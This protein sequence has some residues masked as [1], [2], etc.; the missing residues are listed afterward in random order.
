VREASVARS[1][2]AS[3]PSAARTARASPSSAAALA[4]AHADA[5]VVVDQ[6]LRVLG[7]SGRHELE[8]RG[9]GREVRQPLLAQLV[10]VGRLDRDEARAQRLAV[11]R[12]PQGRSRAG[13]AARDHDAIA[14]HRVV[15]AHVLDQALER[16][17]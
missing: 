4:R 5:G 14:L 17:L 1:G 16:A 13:A 15:P 6:R 12:A 7:S 3:I 10:R 8:V 11:H 2:V 9:R